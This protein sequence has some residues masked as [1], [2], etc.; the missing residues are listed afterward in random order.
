MRRTLVTGAAVSAATAALV[1]VLA[2]TGTGRADVVG[3]A[4]VGAWASLAALVVLAVPDRVVPLSRRWR[5]AGAALSLPYGVG[6]L[7][8]AVQ[9]AAEPGPLP[10][11]VAGDLLSFAAAPGWAAVLLLVPRPSGPAGRLPRVLADAAAVASAVALLFWLLAF[12]G[13]SADPA[14]VAGAVATQ[15]VELLLWAFVVQL[16]V[17]SAQRGV[18]V[19]AFAATLIISGDLAYSAAV[20]VGAAPPLWQQSALLAASWPLMAVALLAVRAPRP[21]PEVVVEARA[22]LVTVAILALCGAAAVIDVVVFQRPFDTVGGVLLVLLLLACTV[23]ELVLQ[24]QRV[25]QVAALSEAA[26]HDPLTGLANRRALAAALAELSGS[27]GPVGVVV[28]DLDGFKR[29]NDTL[30]HATGDRLVVAVA[31][32]LRRGHPDAVVARLGG[33]EF[34]VV[35]ARPEREVLEAAHH[36][37]ALVRESAGTVPGVAHARVSASIG[38]V[39]ADAAALR[40]AADAL[41][42]VSRASAAMQEAK[43]RGRDRVVRHEDVAGAAARQRAVLEALA[44]ALETGRGLVARVQPVVSLASGAER[45]QHVQLGLVAPEVGEA[46]PREVL[47][48]ARRHSLDA[49]L[50]HRALRTAL[51]GDGDAW[52]RVEAHQLHDDA[53]LASTAALLRERATAPGRLV[54]ELAGAVTPDDARAVAAVRALDALGAHVAVRGPG[55]RGGVL[56]PDLPR[57]PVRAVVLGAPA[58][59]LTASREDLVVARGVV[60]LAHGLGMRVLAEGVA[61]AEQRDALAAAGVDLARGPLWAADRVPEPA[62]AG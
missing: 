26:H 14:T 49:A 42:V 50:S 34:A 59:A 18:V 44:P 48:V 15:L 29:V 11:P 7:V 23:R 45:G 10:F 28:L 43:L 5:L 53:W 24:R 3:T 33:D 39:V 61:T 20:L 2:L 31:G 9:K 62:A 40:D 51:E 36:L 57:L 58:G 46:A 56:L 12:A 52:V 8:L 22:S 21:R 54:L 37:A 30:G 55:T 16:A 6:Q 1:A 38:V 4:L 19:M 32:A 27:T 41:A 60:G 13:R 25:R 47:R 35:L 17:I